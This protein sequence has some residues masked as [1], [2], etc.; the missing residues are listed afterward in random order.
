MA[1]RNKDGGNGGDKDVDALLADLD[2]E[3]ARDYPGLIPA[4]PK[5]HKKVAKPGKVFTLGTTPDNKPFVLPE[6][7]ITQHMHFL[8]APGSGNVAW[9]DVAQALKDINYDGPVVIESFTA[10]VD[11]IAKA[12][13]IWRPMAP[14]QDEIAYNG[15][16]FLRELL[17]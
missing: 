1:D 8:G 2:A 17:G 10:K 9:N 3:M 6:E 13:A 14:T 5:T 7:L 15:V 4:N 11:A 12:A 16:K